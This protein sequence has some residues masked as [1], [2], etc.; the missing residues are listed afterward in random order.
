MKTSGV[1]LLKRKESHS[2]PLS[3]SKFSFLKAYNI[4]RFGQV[5]RGAKGISLM[6][7][8]PL[9]G[10]EMPELLKGKVTIAFQLGQNTEFFLTL[11]IGNG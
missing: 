11:I 2:Y 6:K 4:A 7:G 1:Q 5:F 3:M 9:Q 8:N 10:R